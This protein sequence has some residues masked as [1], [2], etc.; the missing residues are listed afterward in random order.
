VL[1]ATGFAE[2]AGRREDLHELGGKR[3][4]HRVCPARLVA[5]P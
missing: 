2:Q 4:A 1:E 3:Y 5:S